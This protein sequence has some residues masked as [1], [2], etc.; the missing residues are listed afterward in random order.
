MAYV[1]PPQMRRLL[2]DPETIR[3]AK[4]KVVEN[5]PMLGPQEEGSLDLAKIGK[6]WGVEEW[7]ATA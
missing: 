7:V 6:K 3:R 4:Q 2:A 5:N 1:I